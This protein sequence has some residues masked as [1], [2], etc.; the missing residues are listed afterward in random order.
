MLQYLFL[1]LLYT[2]TGPH[3]TSE[4]TQAPKSAHAYHVLTRRMA[5]LNYSNEQQYDFVSFPFFNN[6]S[7]VLC[8]F[9]FEADR[10]NHETRLNQ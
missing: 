10:R 9:V 5:K 1:I 3:G 2:C 8:F 6:I 4:A 7:F